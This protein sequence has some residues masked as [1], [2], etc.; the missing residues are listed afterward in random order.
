MTALTLADYSQHPDYLIS[1][2]AD[3]LRAASPIMDNLPFHDAGSLSIEVIREA[4]LPN[5]SWRRAGADHGSSKGRVDAIQETAFSF[6]NSIDVDKVYIKN[7]KAIYDARA[8]FTKQTVSA[9]AFAFNDKFINGVPTT[10]PDAITGLWFRIQNDH[11]ANKVNANGLDISSDAAALAANTQS[12]FDLL[13]ALIYELPEGGKKLLVCN[14][15]MLQRFWSL[16]R[17]SGVLS[18]V[19][20]QLGRELYEYKGATFLDA[21]YKA[22]Q[23]SLII[24]N[25]ET[26][27]GTALTGGSAT[28][29]YGVTVGQEFLTGWQEYG[30]DVEDMGRLQNGV[31]WRTVVDW[32]VGLA[33]THP[34]SIYQMHGLI[35]A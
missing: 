1:G 14:K 20:D 24:G 30:L 3:V 25:V 21:G 5:I 31:T 4:G 19:K 22:D 29:I 11:A 26:N 28:S 8:L 35:A 13:D 12:F 32:V 6:G 23:T 34:R 33:I 7:K 27:A 17:Q 2:V 16:A 9:M 10:D 18:T 15:T